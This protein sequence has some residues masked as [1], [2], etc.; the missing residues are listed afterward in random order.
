MPWKLLAY[1][2]FGSRAEAMKEEK[3]I[4]KLKSRIQTLKAFGLEGV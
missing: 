4:K 1:K 2:S 3:R